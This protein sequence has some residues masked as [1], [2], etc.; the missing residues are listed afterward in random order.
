MTTNNILDPFAEII[1]HLQE[2]TDKQIDLEQLN[3]TEEKLRNIL[4]QLQFELVNA[5]HQKNWEEVNKFELAVSECQ[6][7]LNKVRAAIINVSIIGINPKNR[8]QMQQ[9]L[10]EIE[11]ARKTQVYIDLA[12]RLLGFLRRLFL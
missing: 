12:I 3:N 1:S 4:F 7:T 2:V 9:I 8:A 10:E 11:T 6:L 5:Q